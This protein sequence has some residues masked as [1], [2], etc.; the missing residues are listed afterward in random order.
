MASSL[1]QAR[2]S[3]AAPICAVVRDIGHYHHVR[4]Q[5]LARLYQSSPIDVLELFNRGSVAAF[6]RG[7][8]GDEHYRR[9]T[10]LPEE[11]SGSVSSPFIRDHLRRQLDVTSPAAICVSGW[12]APEGLAALEWCLDRRVP[13]ILMSESQAGDYRRHPLKEAVKR[14]LVRLGSAGL[15]G[16]TRHADYLA[17]L[18]MPRHR[19]FP[20]YDVVDNDHFAQGAEAARREPAARSRLQLPRHFFLASARFVPKKNLPRLLEAFS[21]YRSLATQPWDL[22]LLGDGP[23]QGEVRSTIARLGLETAVS[24]RGFKQYIELPSYYGLAVAFV[25]PSTTEQWGLVVNEAMAAG[26]PVLVSDRCGCAPDL[27][28][29]GRNGFS[30]DPYDTEELA[31]LMLRLTGM[32]ETQRADMG[33]ASLEIIGR[34]TPETFATNLM[35]AV[36]VALS[37]PRPKASAVDKALLWALIHR[38]GAL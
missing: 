7:V 11:A 8:T 31:R 21:R 28:Q 20:G 9:H 3:I 33:K 16:G 35:K 1:S 6:N 19:I 22:V 5:A 2:S 29:D 14:R 10:V 32:S 18:G 4:F 25:H 36:E 23:L 24:L 15:V 27:V 26:L 37:A 30:F 38:P 17:A 13:G 34:W 12:S